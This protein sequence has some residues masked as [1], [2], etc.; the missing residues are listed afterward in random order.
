MSDESWHKVA[1]EA[2]VDPDEPLRVRVGDAQIALCNVDGTIYAIDNICTHEYA[3]LSDGFI[4][5]DCIEC[6]LHQA[7]FHIPTGK[8]LGPP[9][10]EDLATYPVKV[11]NGDVFVQLLAAGNDPA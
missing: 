7:Q 3:E 5:G 4:E 9:A 8:A 1:G 6:P 11:E 2:D 10:D